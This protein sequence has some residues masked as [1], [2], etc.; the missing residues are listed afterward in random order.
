MWVVELECDLGS[1]GD[2]EDAA[3][4][5]SAF[6]PGLADGGQLTRGKTR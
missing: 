1:S 3:F 2:E 5:D 6:H 4:H